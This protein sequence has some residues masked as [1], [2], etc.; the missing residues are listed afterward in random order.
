MKTKTKINWRTKI[1]LGQENG[2]V[3]V[4][5]FCFG[6]MVSGRRR[7]CMNGRAKISF[8]QFREYVT[9]RSP[10]SF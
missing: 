7:G 3:A 2:S 6:I 8:L 9:V 5:R 1:A 10:I 4:I